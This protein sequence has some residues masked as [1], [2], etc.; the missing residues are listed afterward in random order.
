MIIKLVIDGANQRVRIIPKDSADK[1][2]LE[3]I[4]QW[5]IG[6]VHVSRDTYASLRDIKQID[7]VLE[8]EQKEDDDG[9]VTVKDIDYPSIGL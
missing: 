7:L 5:D 3:Y 1:K 2:L 8:T 9:A 6:R 4:A